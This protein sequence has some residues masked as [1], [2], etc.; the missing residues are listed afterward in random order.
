[1]NC[2]QKLRFHGTLSQLLLSLTAGLWLS[3]KSQRQHMWP[4]NKTNK[5]KNQKTKL[6]TF[7]LLWVI[8]C[9]VKFL[10]KDLVYKILVLVHSMLLLQTPGDVLCQRGGWPSLDKGLLSY[11]P[12]PWKNCLLL[13]GGWRAECPAAAQGA[14][15]LPE[16][17]SPSLFSFGHLCTRGSGRKLSCKWRADVTAIHLCEWTRP[18]LRA[19]QCP[20]SP[21]GR[22]RTRAPQLMPHFFE[23]LFVCFGSFLLLDEQK[24]VRSLGE[25]S[26]SDPYFWDRFV[27]PQFGFIPELHQ[28]PLRTCQGSWW[29][30]GYENNVC[31][32][33]VPTPQIKEDLL[34][35]D[36]F[37]SIPF[38][39]HTTRGGGTER[40]SASGVG[41]G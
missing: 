20:A 2:V 15:W 26:R 30:R 4:K 17:L 33:R 13:L 35:S 27:S 5:Q 16:A 23:V 18:L 12:N 10:S 32:K 29:K 8:F 36:D 34:R 21:V 37:N 6:L 40:L 14:H 9:V 41:V 31:Q 24:G 38:T 25:M 39:H 19:L 28:S 11:N 7:W 3:V 22:T 1:M